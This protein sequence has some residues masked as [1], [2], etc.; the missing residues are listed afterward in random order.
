MAMGKR[1]RPQAG[2]AGG[3]GGGKTLLLFLFGAGGGLRC[4]G[5]LRLGHPLLEFVHATG[6]IDKLLLAGVKG[7]ADVA[8][9]DQKGCTGGTRLDDVAAGATNFRRIVFRMYVS[10]H[11]KGRSK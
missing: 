6:R 3:R 11:N 2:K 9:T 5:G 7:M 10:F 4:L 1:N 8:N